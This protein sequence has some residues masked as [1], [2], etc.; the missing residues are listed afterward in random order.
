MDE[1][2]VKMAF[3]LWQGVLDRLQ[4]D[5]HKINRKLREILEEEFRFVISLVFD[6]TNVEEIEKEV[7]EI[8]RKVR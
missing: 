4:F 8:I 6:I 1:M 3:A 7:K 5:E 2:K